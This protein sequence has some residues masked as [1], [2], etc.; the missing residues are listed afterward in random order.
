MIATLMIVNRWSPAR[1]VLPLAFIFTLIVS[2]VSF[3][4]FDRFDPQRR[5]T[6]LWF[7]LYV[8]SA[9]IAGYFLWRYRRLTPTNA[10]PHSRPW[11]GW[12]LTQS[13]ILGLYGLGLLL[14]PSFFSAFWPWRLDV[15]HA[16]VYSAIFITAAAG[17]YIVARVAAPIEFLTLGLGFMIL[18]ASSVSGLIMVDSAVHRVNWSL[19]GTWLWAGIFSALFLSGAMMVRGAYVKYTQAKR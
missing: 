10:T 15:F 4:Y 19:P 6:W 17:S 18:G 2:A 8:G 1:L 16:Q 13:G 12:L 11:R 14:L 3:L 9:L 5:A 7:V